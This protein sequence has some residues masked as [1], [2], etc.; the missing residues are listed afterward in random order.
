[1]YEVYFEGTA[2]E[3]RRGTDAAGWVVQH[4]PASS[5]KGEE[6]EQEEPDSDD[7]AMEWT[8]LLGVLSRIWPE[9]PPARLQQLP[10][11]EIS[12][13]PLPSSA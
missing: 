13:L 6:Q 4:Y 2:R 8:P 9:L 12:A 3:R 11:D 1:M 5:G 7:E 10:S